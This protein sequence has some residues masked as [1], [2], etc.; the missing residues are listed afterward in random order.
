[1]NGIERRITA[2]EERCYRGVRRPKYMRLYIGE[3]VA[4]AAYDPLTGEGPTIERIERERSASDPVWKEWEPFIVHGGPRNPREVL[5]HEWYLAARLLHDRETGVDRRF[6]KREEP[7][8]GIDLSAMADG[9]L[10]ERSD[11]L[12]ELR[13]PLVGSE[14]ARRA[15]V[16]ILPSGGFRFATADDLRALVAAAT[17][18][19]EAA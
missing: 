3:N 13:S 12:W 16:S 4:D 5:D 6:A 10:R 1:M 2:L 7:T 8:E 18:E 15:V 11:L 9:E 19:T 14:A 17:E